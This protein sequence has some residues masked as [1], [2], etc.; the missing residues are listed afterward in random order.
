MFANIKKNFVVNCNK[1]KSYFSAT[2]KKLIEI[3]YDFLD[4]Y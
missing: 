1:K 4:V 2:F 3:S